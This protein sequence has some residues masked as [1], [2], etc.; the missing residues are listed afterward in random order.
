MRW[1][2]VLV[3][4]VLPAA[5]WAE[6]G[7][8]KLI[9]GQASVLRAGKII[10]AKA[11]L[12]IE[13]TDVVVTGKDGGFDKAASEAK[14]AA[15]KG[16][17]ALAPLAAGNEEMFDGPRR[18]AI[19]PAELASALGIS[20]GDLIELSTGLGAAVRVWARIGGAHIG[21]PGEGGLVLGPSGLRLLRGQA[22]DEIEIRAIRPATN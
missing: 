11:G 16:A 5:A 14:R 3:F 13:A 19:V 22:G 4:I 20:E 21:G 18:Q 7:Q 1:L 10:A 12:A 9:V 15:L 2:L 6:I 8:I 17:R